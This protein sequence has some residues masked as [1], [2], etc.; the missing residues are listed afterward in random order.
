[1]KVGI[2]WHR[3]PTQSYISSV[4]LDKTIYYSLVFPT[5]KGH[6]KSTNFPRAL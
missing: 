2:M 5:I 4:I 6:N 3:I 1:M